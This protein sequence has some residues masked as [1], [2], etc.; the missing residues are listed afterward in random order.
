MSSEREH[1]R[2]DTHSYPVGDNSREP[3]AKG[4][5]HLSP[6]QKQGRRHR[7]ETTVRTFFYG[8][9][10][11]VGFFFYPTV[12]ETDSLSLS[13]VINVVFVI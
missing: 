6:P 7:N 2:V 12:T 9:T 3:R 8:R 11:I 13:D 1:M 4:N 5:E 10:A